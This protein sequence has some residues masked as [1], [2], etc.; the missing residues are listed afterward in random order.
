MADRVRLSDLPPHVQAKIRARRPKLGSQPVP[1]GRRTAAP[2]GKAARPDRPI[3]R[4]HG[5]GDTFTAWAPAERHADQPGHRRIEWKESD[6]GRF[7]DENDEYDP[8]A[9]GRWIVNSR[10]VVRSKRG[11]KALRDLEAALIKADA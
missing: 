9:E 8:L 4:C 6:V 1:S 10:A 7:D 5:C 11:Q 2:P 3:Y